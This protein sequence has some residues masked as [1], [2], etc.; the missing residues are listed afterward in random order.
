MNNY[1]IDNF[2][3]LLKEGS[4]EFKMYPTKRVWHSIYNN[5]HPGRRWPSIAMC[6]T[7]ISILLL[8]GFLNTH[9]EAKNLILTK[10]E[11]NSTTYFNAVTTLL[12][13][14]ISNSAVANS[15]QFL[16]LTNNQSL[17]IFN[18]NISNSIKADNTFSNNKFN[19]N[20][21]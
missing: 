12:N 7:L 18:S 21:Y 3:K 19:I 15:L 4:D 9:N 11:T 1:N 8:V 5:I 14:P 16:N 20:L 17:S 13:D 10:E 2:E 6:I